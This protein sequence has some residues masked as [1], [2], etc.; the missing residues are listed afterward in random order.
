MSKTV[1]KKLQVKELPEPQDFQK[2]VTADENGNL[3]VSDLRIFG[4]VDGGSAESKYLHY[5][6]IQGGSAASIPAF[7]IGGGNAYNN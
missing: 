1:L 3:A 6:N 4:G 7:K 2:T 5:Q